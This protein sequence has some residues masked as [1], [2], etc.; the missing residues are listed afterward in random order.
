VATGLLANELEL[1]NAARRNL[2]WAL[3]QQ[4]QSGWF[5]TNAFTPGK[6][7]FTHTIAYAIRGFVESGVLLDDEHYLSAALAA[8]RAM[9]HV[10]RADGWLAG[11]YGEDWQP[12]ASYSCL[13]GVA[14]MSLNWT[15]LAQDSGV[16]DLRENAR[17][18]I[19][20]VKRT[21]RLTDA[22]DAVRGG[23]AG[24]SPIWGDYSRF[25]YPNWAAKFFADALMMDMQ[26]AAIPPVA[27]R[28]VK[29]AEPTHG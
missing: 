12:R 25:E 8:A 1:V 10:Q 13:T 26:D 2:D 21:Q 3:R 5:A 20:Y 4:T 27:T 24:S 16:P 28:V 15:R 29:S 11:T 17:R 23:I 6:A 19:G 22:N 9:A 7:P 18:A 14:Q